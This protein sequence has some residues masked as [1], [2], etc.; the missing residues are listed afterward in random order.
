MIQLLLRL[1]WLAFYM[2]KQ[3][4]MKEL[5]TFFWHMAISKGQQ[6]TMVTQSIYIIGGEH[7]Q[8]L[9]TCV[10][11]FLYKFLEM[12]SSSYCLSLNG[13]VLHL[14]LSLEGQALF[15]FSIHIL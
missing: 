15:L 14:L 13:N 12:A 11:R 3:S 1:K 4:V 9:I 7:K 10:N 5:G 2:S 8:K 6:A